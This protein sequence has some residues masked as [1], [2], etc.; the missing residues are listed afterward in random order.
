MIV[1]TAAAQIWMQYK[2]P[3]ERIVYSSSSL[4]GEPATSRVKLALQPTNDEEAGEQYG[5]TTGLHDRAFD[6]P[7]LWKAQPI[8]WLSN[9]TLGI[10]KAEVERIKAA[11]VDASCDYATMDAEG[12]LHVERNPPDEAWYGGTSIA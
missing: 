3:L 6:H 9:D 12:K 4:G 7:A 8:V 2:F 5:N 11:S 10:G 1:V